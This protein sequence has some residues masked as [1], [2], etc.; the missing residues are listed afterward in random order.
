M[1][2][3]DIK[4]PVFAL[5]KLWGQFENPLTSRRVRQVWLLFPLLLLMDLFPH[6]NGQRPINPLHDLPQIGGPG[7]GAFSE[8]CPSGAF[9]TGLALHAADDVDAVQ[10][11][12]LGRDGSRKIDTPW[13]G[14]PGGKLVV[15]LCPPETPAIIALDVAAEGQA[16]VIVN[17]IHIYCG[18]RGPNPSPSTHP[19]A[20]FDGPPYKRSGGPFAPPA[21]APVHGHQACQAGEIAVG[22]HGSSGV[23]LDAVGL[24]CSRPPQA[25]PDPGAISLGRVKTS[26]VGN[27]QRSI[28]DEAAS[29]R[30]RNSPAAPSLEAQCK[31]AQLAANERND[32]APGASGAPISI[33]DAAQ[34][35]LDRNAPEAA[36][37]VAKCRAAG[38][39]QN[40]TTPADQ[41][42]LAG[43]AIATRDPLIAELRRRQPASASLRGFDIGI[44][45]S[46]SQTEWG[47]G[48]QKVL[49]SLSLAEQDLF[50]IAASFMLDRNRN[51]KLAATGASIAASDPVVARARTQNPDVRYWLGFDIASGLFGN[52][53]LGGAGHT[54]TGPGSDA[55][56]NALSGPAQRGFNDSVQ[57]HL[58]RK[59]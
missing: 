35:A 47:P 43:E 39:G 53:A 10:M 41:Y 28:C 5:L 8:T 1:P 6:L 58:S 32:L 21:S 9:L 31:A 22:L 57:L 13:H 7:G 24:F 49:D 17:N 26:G 15:L 48:K 33:C 29:A 25:T 2:I 23:W 19:S 46:G 34:S 20:V 4:F 18:L 59:Y 27:S 56:R 54:S 37:L 14:G 12:C 55:I 40:L 45:V 16:T 51:S 38:G 42:A 50:K 11:L 44:G 36:D 3:R 30:A 52:P